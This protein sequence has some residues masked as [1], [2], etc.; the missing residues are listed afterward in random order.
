MQDAYIIELYF[1]IHVSRFAV[2]HYLSILRGIL[3][4]NMHGTAAIWQKVKK[5]FFEL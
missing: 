1:F 3:V 4:F 5:I 2:C